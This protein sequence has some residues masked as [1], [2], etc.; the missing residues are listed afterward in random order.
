MR[1]ILVVIS[2][3]ILFSHWGKSQTNEIH[4]YSYMTN[5]FQTEYGDSLTF[6]GYGYYLG[7]GNVLPTTLPAP[8]LKVKKDEDVSIK[9]HNLSGEDHTIHLH[10][11]DVDTRN[12]G[13]PH[14]WWPVDPNDSIVY[15]FNSSHPGA[16][17]YHC[18]VMTVHHLAMGM[19]GMIIVRNYPDSLHMYNGGPGFNKEYQYLFS[20][21]D[22]SWNADPIS[23]GQLHDFHGNYYMVNG[24]SGW[25]MFSGTDEV[26]QAAA[27]D[28]ILVHVG[29]MG[30]SSVQLNFPPEMNAVVHMS[31]GRVL[32][33]AIST[34]SLR[35]YPGER[36]E[37][38]FRP[39]VNY[40]GYIN[41]VHH[42]AVM[43]MPM[44]TNFIGINSY[45][46]PIGI[47]EKEITIATSKIYPNPANNTV[48]AEAEKDGKYLISDRAGNIVTIG[49]VSKGLNTISV[50]NLV[51]GFYIVNIDGVPQK[52]IITR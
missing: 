26:I 29:N 18:H 30:Y 36:Y 4:L 28:S 49:K 51:N 12:D 37:I 6:W 47:D 5:K 17:L 25:Q 32:P 39:T 14:T 34:D 48:M 31:D 13:V 40:T 7:P 46:H 41:A 3:F 2:F 11:L 10:G 8:L 16:Y 24:K 22:T 42:N 44:G 1:R 20:D 43:D 33:S 19:Y 27:G 45:V 35:I 23:P 52:L 9:F 15:S 38:M 21:M 50:T